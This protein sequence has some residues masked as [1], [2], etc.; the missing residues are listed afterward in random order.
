[1]PFPYDILQTQIQSRSFQSHQSSTAQQPEAELC[2]LCEVRELGR[3]PWN[4]KKLV[5]TQVA[6]SGFSQ[7]SK[8]RRGQYRNEFT[9][10]DLTDFD[11]LRKRC[12]L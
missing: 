4:S 8:R 2:K 12:G 9:P 7:A 3:P 5:G 10:V 1:M 11:L 6:Q